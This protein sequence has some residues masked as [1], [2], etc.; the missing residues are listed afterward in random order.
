[1]TA[2]ARTIRIACLV[3][4][5]F[6]PILLSGCNA[7]IAGVVAWLLLDDDDGDKKAPTTVEIARVENARTAPA[8]SMVHARLTNKKSRP[9]DIVVELSLDGVTFVPATLVEPRPGTPTVPGTSTVPGK[10]TKVPTSKAGTSHPIGWDALADLG[11]DAYRKVSLRITPDKGTSALSEVEVGNDAPAVAS[12]DLTAEEDGKVLVDVVL[13][14]STPD[15]VDLLIEFAVDPGEE[16]EPLFAPASVVGS[17]EGLATSIEGTG[18]QFRW[19][20]L[21][22]VGTYD[23]IALVRVTPTDRV[24]PEPGTETVAGKTGEPAVGAVA[25]DNNGPPEVEILETEF[26][27]DPDARGAVAIR[28]VVRD[29]ESNP[30]DVAIQWA[31]E[32]ED[33]LDLPDSLDSDPALREEM[34]L[35]GA[36]REVARVATIRPDIV[37][38]PLE[39]PSS[40]LAIE[41][42]QVLATWI[43]AAAELR[44]I[45]GTQVLSGRSLKIVRPNGEGVDATVCS[46]APQ[47]GILAV[48]PP[49]RSS[50][51]PGSVLRIDL[52]GDAGPLRLASSPAGVLHQLV[53]DTGADAPG[54]GNFR[55]R[56]TPFDR[57]P[58]AGDPCS[59]DAPPWDPESVARGERGTADETSG[60]RSILGPFLDEDPD[61]LRLYPVDRPVAL[62]VADV[63]GDGRTDIVCGASFSDTIVIFRQTAPGAYDALRLSDMRLKG[64]TDLAVRDIDG[65]GD[66]DMAVTGSTTRNVLVIYQDPG[67]GF[68]ENRV[69]LTAGGA[70]VHPDQIAAA[71]IDGDGDV[72]LVV[73]D[74]GS[75]DGALRIFFRG[76]GPAGSCGVEEAGFR[77]CPVADPGRAPILDLEAGDLLE[78]GIP[79][80]VGVGGDAFTVFA[81]DLAASASQGKLVATIE[82][83]AVPGSQLGGIALVD[84]D[85]DQKTD[86]VSTDRRDPSL[87]VV[88]RDPSGGFASPTRL[89]SLGLRGPVAVAAADLDRNGVIDFAAADAGDP[90]SLYG[91]NVHVFLGVPS[92]DALSSR[93]WSASAL[94]REL[95]TDRTRV[96]PVKVVIAD[97]DGNGSPEIVSVDEGQRDIAIFRTTGVGSYREP[98]L[99]ITAGQAI[100][101]PSHLLPADLDGD[102]R[103]DLVAAGR[104]T[105]DVTWLR[106]VGADRFAGLRVRVPAPAG[107][108]SRSGP[109]AAAAGDVDGDGEADIVTANYD[110]ASVSIIYGTGGT[111]GH[112]ASIVESTGLSGPQAVAIADFDGDGLLDIA[113]AGG[114][115]KDVR[116]L[117]QRADGTFSDAEVLRPGDGSGIDMRGLAALAAADL[118][119]DGRTDV[120]VACGLSRNVIVFAKAADGAGFEDPLAIAV[121]ADSTPVG[122]VA[123]DLDGNGLLDLVTA[124]Y[125]STAASL[126]IQNAGG[127]Y[128]LTVV[129]GQRDYSAAAVAVRD[130][131]RDGTVDL[132]IAFAGWSDA[133][134][135][136]WSQGVAGGFPAAPALRIRSPGLQ[137]PVGLVAADL[138]GD[139]DPDLAV[140]GRDSRNVVVFF[141]GR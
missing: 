20:S 66:L 132:A 37:E 116:V 84:A 136:V 44:G 13:V 22:D 29:A 5:G 45:A 18:H 46:Y 95:G 16:G 41:E 125:G 2:I 124:N 82:R 24:A 3:V 30:V 87:V 88:G 114:L 43:R 85:G 64:L 21:A 131:N 14:D 51:E 110:A 57:V 77:A 112:R 6:A 27:T 80:I 70:L 36:A 115:S 123:A 73:S 104:R 140:A 48:D 141:G 52:G 47:A 97:I 74:S 106:Q 135:G 78:G 67:L 130:L 93:R 92:S 12:L 137:G 101:A 113:V 34:I 79:E 139:G 50:L 107:P 105:D 32:G 126:L 69:L 15:P 8:A 53:W 81:L 10:L 120:A 35:G 98:G 127:G 58:L 25:L 91:G 117:P 62:A 11:D 63:D 71:D 56:I 40:G 89:R 1:M 72:D 99:T 86:L 42:G 102:G 39:S 9:T 23:A 33:F 54:G 17:T 111:F 100:P 38:G 59:G 4:C 128:D 108:A 118:D 26:L 76:G 7:G 96:S 28:F 138:D 31:A 65:D 90:S 94:R 83:I 60:E 133:W 19:D 68:F 55:I 75:A 109:V 122:L 134:I 121:G 129:P 49:S 119:R 103:V 61:I